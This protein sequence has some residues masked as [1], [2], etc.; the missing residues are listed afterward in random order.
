MARASSEPADQRR[1]RLRAADRRASIIDAA[2]AAFAESGF[3]RA[4]MSQIA[5]RLGVT[6][7]VLFQNFGSKAALY[8]AVVAHASGQMCAMMRT[9]AAETDSIAALLAHLLSPGHIDELHAPGSFGVIF[10]DAMT[11]TAE[12][13][14][15]QAVRQHMGELADVLAEV[16]T[17]GQRTGELRSDLDPQAAAWAVLSFL[18]GHRFRAAVMPDRQRLETHIA[19]M[20]LRALLDDRAGKV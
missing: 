17:D 15:E 18:S 9:V 2:T 19:H 4:T 11:M 20:T 16:I 12:P 8:A 6:E 13:A 1:T 5:T 10:A 3:Q 7:P 14:V